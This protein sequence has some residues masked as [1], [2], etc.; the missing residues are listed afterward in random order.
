MLSREAAH[1]ESETELVE[2]LGGGELIPRKTDFRFSVEY[3]PSHKPFAIQHFLINQTQLGEGKLGRVF[4]AK[5]KESRAPLVLKCMEKA[6]I[7]AESVI[8]QVRQEI[9][10]HSRLRHPNIIKM[11]GYFQDDERCMVA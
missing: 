4:R 7:E 11:Y 10:I 3:L 5:E 6:T 8:Y 2:P 1:A 9:E